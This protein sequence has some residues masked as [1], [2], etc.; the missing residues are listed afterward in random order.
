MVAADP[1]AVYRKNQI[2]TVS[3]E[4]RVLLLYNGALRHLGQGSAAIE[5]RDIQATSDHLCRAQEIVATLLGAL[6]RE[7]GASLADNLTGLYSYILR[8]ITRAN[9]EKDIRPL[10]EAAF[11][12]GEV[13]DGWQE[14]MVAATRPSGQTG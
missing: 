10:K 1:L 14:A 4:R 7:A 2:T 8:L 5:R 11:L 3:A 6:D 9:L 13:R 12:L